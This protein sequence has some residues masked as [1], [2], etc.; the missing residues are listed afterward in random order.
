MSKPRVAIIGLDCAEPSLLFDRWA[1]SLPNLDGLRR[2]G[3]WGRLETVVPAITVPAWSC[4]A[5]GK[6]PGTLGVYGFRNRVDH[7]YDRLSVAMSEQIREPRLWDILSRA[8]K[9]VIVLSVPQTYPVRPVN[10]TMVSCFLT[11]DRDHQYTYPNELRREIDAWVGEY[12]F[13]VKGFRT[14]DKAWLLEQ[15]YVMTRRRFEVARRLLDT[16]S[17]DFFMMVEIGVDRMHHGFWKDLDEGHRGHDP[18]SPYR[19]AIAEYYRYVDK[20]IGTLLE[21]FDDDTSVF[22]VSDHGAR[23]LDGGVCLNE[24]L[25]R[26]G[27]LVLAEE[28]DFSGGPM[29]LQDLKVDWSRTRV[30]GDG[31]YYGRVF[32]NLK[33]REPNGAVAPEEYES[34]RNELI[35]RIEAIGDENG[36]PTGTRCFKPDSLYHEV[37]G[38]APDLL[39]YFGDLGWRSIGSVGWGQIHVFENDTGPDDANHA[40]FGSF[41]YAHPKQDLGGRELEGLKLLQIAPTVLRLLNTPVPSDMQETVISE[42]F[43]E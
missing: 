13:D 43:A 7:S 17:W 12:M 40:Q 26:E 25:I 23:R 20:E 36:Q 27:Y 8:G 10:G 35:A 39:V 15:I 2:R 19:E 22:V 3:A 5:S 24:W 42:L 11:P 38:V 30:W 37:R 32:V 28:P 34:I 41:L 14:S 16:R 1:G 6:D 33:G 18:D 4:M 21:R 31:G 29:R 9:E